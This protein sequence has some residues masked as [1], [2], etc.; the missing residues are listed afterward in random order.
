MAAAG[1]CSSCACAGQAGLPPSA[2][3]GLQGKMTGAAEAV[4]AGEE[5]SW[6]IRSLVPQVL[7]VVNGWAGGPG[8]EIVGGGA[9]V[10]RARR[11][12]I[13]LSPEQIGEE[14][15][16]EESEHTKQHTHVSMQRAVGANWP[17]GQRE[18]A[19]AVARA[20]PE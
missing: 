2:G 14:G 16:G 19:V 12:F 6:P 15:E 9:A 18:A 3:Q 8:P 7:A 13:V 11:A 1:R 4:T 20:G 17:E 5:E 10:S